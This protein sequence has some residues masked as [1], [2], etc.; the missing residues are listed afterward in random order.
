LLFASYHAYLDH[1]SGA[2]LATRDLFEDLAAHG[3]EC[4]VVCGPRLDYGDSRGLERVFEEC[5]VGYH[6][7]RCAPAGGIPYELFHY[8][9][10]GVPV[11]QYRPLGDDLSRLPTRGEG[12]PFLDV[13]ERACAKFGIN[14]VLTYGGPPLGPHLIR[15]SRRQGARVVFTLH[16]LAYS[17]PDLFR[18]A[19]VVWV[20]SE[21]ARRAY[22]ERLGL[23]AETVAWPWNRARAVA[24]R[25]DGRFVTFVN[26]VPA[27][28]VAWFVGIARE[29]WR[30][31]PE[32]PLLVVEGRGN[33]GW[34]RRLPADLS[35][36][37]NIHG[38]HST[39][40]PRQFYAKTRIVVVPSLGEETFGRVAAES[41]ANGIPVLASSRGAL[42]ET[43]GSAGFVFDIP[44]KYKTE[45]T[46][47]PTAKEVGPWV[48][49]IER[50][51][52]DPAFYDEHH[53]RSLARAESW[54]DARLRSDIAASLQRVAAEDG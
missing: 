14:V 9:L 39:P 16:N 4:R 42:P 24:D 11:T 8:A 2:A 54:E 19:D 33:T 44:E 26:P 5:R 20:P 18:E 48:E 12:I 13:V 32:I 3:W 27:K 1:S 49:V 40:W 36:L 29:L 31:R 52:D 17:D 38:M 21:F 47:I 37:K 45:S 25:I 34:L 51:W 41:L 23:E 53:A 7:E 43:L 10:G 28:G 22:R 35:E 50:L 6:L 46:L 30:R 15:R